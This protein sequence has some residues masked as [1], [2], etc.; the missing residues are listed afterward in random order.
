MGMLQSD[1]VTSQPG[2]IETELV[3]LALLMVGKYS[4]SYSSL[5]YNLYL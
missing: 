2:K 3:F 4:I 1:V 5:Y